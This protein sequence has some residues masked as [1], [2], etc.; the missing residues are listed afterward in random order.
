MAAEPGIQILGPLEIEQGNREGL[1]RT[2][3][4]RLNAGLL[5]GGQGSAAVLKQAEGE[6][7]GFSLAAFPETFLAAFVS[8][9]NRHGDAP[10]GP[11]LGPLLEQAGFTAVDNRITAIHHWCPGGRSRLERFCAY[12]LQFISPELPAL[13]AGATSPAEAGL[14]ETGHDL[15]R[16]RQVLRLLNVEPVCPKLAHLGAK[17]PYPWPDGNSGILKIVFQV[18]DALQQLR[19]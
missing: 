5:A 17:L 11:R 16:V 19:D 3:G 8:H 9:F 6:G 2:E 7:N 13:L 1:N 14:I 18:S 4:E 15:Q 10:A 12:L